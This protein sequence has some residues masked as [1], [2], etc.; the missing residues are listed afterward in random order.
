VSAAIRI[1]DLG[2]MPYR[3][4]WAVQEAAHAQ[5][6][7]GGQERIFLVE[8]PPV[9]TFGRR[10][11]VDQHLIASPE[12]LAQMG[13]EVVQSDRGGDI[14]FHGPGQLVAYPIIRLSDHRLM[15]GS[16][17]RA[18]E[19]GVIAALA[20]MGI[21]AN[22]DKEAIGVWVE[23]AKIC[24]LGVR[25]KRG[26]SLHGIAMNVNT[27][28][29]YF[30]LIVPCGLVGRGVTSVARMLREGAPGMGVVKEVVGRRLVEALGAR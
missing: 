23:G 10:P 11:G 8:H 20:E 27:D 26:V 24:A 14:T 19:M 21:V 6:L 1:E 7:A 25:I 5:V 13:V 17:V 12:T 9:I 22:K 29:S 28:L 15:V 2:T 30:D 4:A 3:D 18:L 16:Y